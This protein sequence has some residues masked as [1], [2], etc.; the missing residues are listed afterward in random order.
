V[1][2]R[3]NLYY[4]HVGEER[5]TVTLY[6]QPKKRR[7]GIGGKEGNWRYGIPLMGESYLAVSTQEKRP[8]RPA[9]GKGEKK[10]PLNLSKGGGELCHEGGL[11]WT[12]SSKPAQKRKKDQ[13]LKPFGGGGRQQKTKRGRLQVMGKKKRGEK[14]KCKDVAFQPS[15]KGEAENK[16]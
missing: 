16:G 6:H 10:P 7:E 2:E 15:T 8:Q 9:Q 5:K 3:I 13:Q 12:A 14:K 1:G 4:P 11:T